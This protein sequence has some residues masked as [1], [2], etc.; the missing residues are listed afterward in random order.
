METVGIVDVP[1]TVTPVPEVIE[2]TLELAAA[3]ALLA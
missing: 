2:A 1:P 3:K